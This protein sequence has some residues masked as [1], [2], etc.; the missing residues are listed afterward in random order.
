M[1]LCKK[2]FG[3]FRDFTGDQKK[4]RAGVDC[5]LPGYGYVEVKTDTHKSCNFFIEYVCANKPS[6]IMTSQAKWWAIYL[7]NLGLVYFLY[8]PGVRRWIKQNL[9]WLEKRYKRTIWSE[10][11]DHAWSAF[12]L[13]IPRDFLAIPGKMVVY[14]IENDELVLVSGREPLIRRRRNVDSIPGRDNE[15]AS[16]PPD[17]DELEDAADKGVDQSSGGDEPVGG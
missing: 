5:W 12:G 3:A 14:R 6:G 7:V 11:A 9:E 4:Q 15:T 17:E 2:R 13:V 1:R 8:V 16:R 10:E